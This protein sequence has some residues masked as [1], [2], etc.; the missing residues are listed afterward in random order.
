MTADLPPLWPDDWA[1][2]PCDTSLDPALTAY[3]NAMASVGEGRAAGGRRRWVYLDKPIHEIEIKG[4][5]L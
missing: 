4:D 5:I 2:E 3:L 1:T